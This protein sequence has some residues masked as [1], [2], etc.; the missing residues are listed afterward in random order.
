MS[1]DE[2]YLW[3]LMVTCW[4]FL[5]RARLT[6]SQERSTYKA[7]YVSTLYEP[8]AMPFE[9]LKPHREAELTQD[10]N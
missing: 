4:D 3:V 9:D 2:C 10:A 7:E 8:I 5:S 1:D 6:S